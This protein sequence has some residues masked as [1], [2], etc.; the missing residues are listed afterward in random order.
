[1]SDFD[2][3]NTTLDEY[4]KS[5]YDTDTKQNSID[6]SSICD[7]SNNVN[8]NGKKICIDCGE[9]INTVV[10]TDKE[11]RY[12]GKSDSRYSSD[13][14]RVQV[15]KSEEKSIYKDVE[16]MNFSDTIINEANS[17]YQKVTGGKIYRGDS[18][19]AII[20]ACIF[21]AY[22]LSGKP[23]TDSTLMHIFNITRKNGLRGIKIVNQ[24]VCKNFDISTSYIT[25]V[26]LIEDI[27]KKFNATDSQI[28]EVSDYYSLIKNKSSF[29]NRARPQS[30]ASAL[31]FYWIQK[32]NKQIT[33]KEF[34]SIVSLSELTINKI[35]KDIKE[36]LDK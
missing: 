27:M 28:K 25:P 3:F 22:K 10:S 12:Y 17:I 30:T 2:L 23:Q 18:R 21:H 35:L 13:P 1:M 16:N 4:N 31:V 33:I 8:E 36:I 15:R 14:N 6:S 19:K 24:N 34:A 32:K 9:V 20:F 29:L 5:F 7:H 26:H 11:W